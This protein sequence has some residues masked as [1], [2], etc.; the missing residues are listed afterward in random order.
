M[1]KQ[2]GVLRSWY[3]DRGFGIVWVSR[4][5][6]YLLHITHV[7]EPDIPV[8]G[9]RVLFDAAPAFKPGHLPL[10]INVALEIAG[11]GGDNA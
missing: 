5:E 6:R 10:A 4:T 9:C 11:E 2:S 1:S 8:V 7:P 3:D